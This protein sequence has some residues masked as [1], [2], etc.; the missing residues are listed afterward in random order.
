V[1]RAAVGALLLAVLLTLIATL[2]SI[3]GTNAI[4]RTATTFMIAVAAVVGLGIYMGNSGIISFVHPGLM[5]IGAYTSGILTLSATT[6]PSVLPDLPGFIAGAEL[7]PFPALAIAI[8][9]AAGVTA[10]IGLPLARLSGG[11]AA[12]YTVAWLIIIHF[13]LIGASGI[14]RG[15]STFFGVPRYVTLW[16][17]LA[18]AVV[19]VIVAR[20]YRDS[21]GGLDLRASREDELAARATGVR[22]VRARFTA[23]V[24]SGAVVGAAGVLLGHS[25]GA[26]SPAQFYIVLATT[27]LAMLIVGGQRTVTGAVVGATAV[28]LLIEVTRRAEGG[29]ALGP[30]DVP[31]VFGLTQL[32]LGVAL[33]LSL[34]VRPE[35]F[36]G[37]SE[38]DEIAFRPRSS[39]SGSPEVRAH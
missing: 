13:V 16:N 31:E 5:A 22:V 25:V 9:V 39:R 36:F 18:L 38:V 35:G 4:E 26:Y 3:A 34:Y 37:R 12:I 29:F 30:I 27:Y 32:A 33:L 19:A 1:A 17:A 14:T 6:K 28:T 8:L 2:V 24:L 23:F 21:R 7:A 20:L 10:V 15:A 11:S